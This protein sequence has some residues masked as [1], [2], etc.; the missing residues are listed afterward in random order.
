MK[1]LL[2]IFLIFNSSYSICSIKDSCKNREVDAFVTELHFFIDS[3]KSNSLMRAR[4]AV[5]VAHFFQVNSMEEEL[6]FTLGYILNDFE[7]KYI[8]P[9][10]VYYYNDEIVLISISGDVTDNF[11]EP[12]FL[13][14]IEKADSIGV[15]NKLLNSGMSATYTPQGLF[16]CKVKGEVSRTFYE[17]A[18][19]IPTKKEIYKLFPLGG[20]IRLIKKGTE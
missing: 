19:N 7:V 11:F 16:F 8:D 5:Y 15:T 17:N 13:K 18:D 1:I 12:L 20:A 6:C 10:F 3:I 9:D 4:H 2:F 14:K